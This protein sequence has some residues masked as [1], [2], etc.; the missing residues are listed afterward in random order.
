MSEDHAIRDLVPGYALGCLDPEDE[1][2]V[3][4]HLP[5]CATCRAELEAYARVTDQ[6]AMAAP[7]VEPPAGLEL[8]LVREIGAR[9]K[10]RL[11]AWRPALAAVA[12]MFA[13]ALVAGNVLQWKGVIRRPGAM[14]PTALLTATL[15]GTGDARDAF[16]TVVLEPGN[17]EGVLAVTGL[18]MLDPAQQY[19]VWLIRGK[20]RRSAGV[21]S[22]NEEGYGSLV[23]AVPADF[24]DFRN[25][26]IS[27]EPAGGSPAPTGARVMAGVL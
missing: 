10:P 7:A 22:V 5:R 1:R 16:G 26:G 21:F 8:R 18:P 20:E 17:R 13:V 27:I 19:Q 14:A 25:L 6:L 11:A 12:A 15:S 2:A 24:R 4:M 9:R 23:L 3:S